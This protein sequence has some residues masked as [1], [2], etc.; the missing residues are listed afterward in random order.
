MLPQPYAGIIMT[1]IRRAQPRLHISHARTRRCF[2][3]AKHNYMAECARFL[4]L[5]IRLLLC[6][7]G[8]MQTCLEQFF[9]A[10]LHSRNLRVS[11]LLPALR[12]RKAKFA[13]PCIYARCP[14]QSLRL[15]SPTNRAR[16]N[17]TGKS[18]GEAPALRRFA[19]TPKQNHPK[20][21]CSEVRAVPRQPIFG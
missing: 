6:Q 9:S 15:L 17:P 20:I 3:P 10:L 7:P 18:S 13:T 5:R 19:G 21:S 11:I 8:I 1:Q 2:H 16:F 12:R 4:P 14:H